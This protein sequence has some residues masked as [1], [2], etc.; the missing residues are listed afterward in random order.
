MSFGRSRPCTTRS[1]RAK[2]EREQLLSRS[3]ARRVLARFERFSE[4]MLDFRGVTI[5]GQAFADEIFRVF[6]REHPEI[7]ILAVNTSN[8][9][10]QMIRHV[11]GD[12]SESLRLF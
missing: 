6:R 7:E 2:Y 8:D 5:I 11:A 12:A 1:K 3:Q 9:I 10:R 4:I